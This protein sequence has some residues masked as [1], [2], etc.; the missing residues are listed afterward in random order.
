TYQKLWK[1]GKTYSSK[2]PEAEVSVWVCNPPPPPPR[3]GDQTAASLNGVLR[4]SDSEEILQG[5]EN[6]CVLI[7]K[8]VYGVAL[9]GTGGPAP[10]RWALP[11]R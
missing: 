10:C 9:V 2:S 6:G 1:R 5:S 11:D 7:L 4:R 8:K 3:G